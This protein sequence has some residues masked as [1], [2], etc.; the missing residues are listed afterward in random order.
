M[1]ELPVAEP[2]R[3]GQRARE[4]GADAVP[5]LCL[6]LALRQRPARLFSPPTRRSSSQ[7]TLKREAKGI[8][9]PQRQS[10][11]WGYAPGRP[12]RGRRPKNPFRRVSGRR[13][14][15][16]PNSSGGHPVPH[17]QRHADYAPG[18]RGGDKCFRKLGKISYL[19]QKLSPLRRC[20]PVPGFAGPPSPER[21]GI[22]AHAGGGHPSPSRGG[23]PEAPGGAASARSGA[24]VS[25]SLGQ[26]RG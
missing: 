12:F 23:W 25:R 9:A 18:F 8:A 22:E 16:L 11:P 1:L 3:V 10:A 5:R 6:C 21:R 15:L 13:R 26:A 4:R 19:G 14:P 17:E 7:P 2:V 20:P 24:G